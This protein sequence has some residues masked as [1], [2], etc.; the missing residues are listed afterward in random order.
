ARLCLRPMRRLAAAERGGNRRLRGPAGAHP[1]LRSSL[2]SLGDRVPSHR[3]L[4]GDLE[5]AGPVVRPLCA[6]ADL[7]SVARRRPAPS[8]RRAAP[9]LSAPARHQKWLAAIRARDYFDAPGGEEATAAVASCEEALARF[10]S[11]A[12]SAA[13]DERAAA[14]V[15]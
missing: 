5:R 9:R 10:E 8:S 12:L 2:R 7:L 13:R 1:R 14:A 6:P 15:R 4:A 11:E 3:E